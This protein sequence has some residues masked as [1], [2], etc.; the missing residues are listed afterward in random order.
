MTQDPLGGSPSTPLADAWHRLGDPLRIGIA[1]TSGEDHEVRYANPAFARL[2]TSDRDPTGRPVADVLPPAVRELLVP[3]LDRT[4]T[5]GE[6]GGPFDVSLVGADASDSI[7][8]CRLVPFDSGGGRRG[9]L[10]ELDDLSTH[11]GSDRLRTPA[12]E[13]LVG[14]NQRLVLA[15]LREQ[16]LAEEAQAGNRA[17]SDFLSAISHELRT[18][19]TAVVGYAELLES[20]AAGPLTE[21]Q[22]RSVERIQ[23][24]ALYLRD[25]INE[26]LKFQG[27]EAGRSRVALYACE[28]REIARQAFSIASAYGTN[29][30]EP[31]LE[32]PD[33][34]IPMRTDQ[35]K[36]KQILVNLLTNALKFT[37]RGSVVLRVKGDGDQVAFAVADTGPGIDPA[38]FERIFER[39]VQLDRGDSRAVSGTGLGLS[40]A[41][42]LVRLLEGKIEVAS[43][44]GDGATFTVRVPAVLSDERS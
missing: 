36:L 22:K 11:R 40:I 5:S 21:K 41:R 39:F 8:S 31:R 16:E 30:V 9:V 20:E 28:G 1:V 4:W 35:Q 6:V 12:E 37:E 18:P 25:L 15:A 42:H 2:L 38:D 3:L 27:L 10:I 13:E 24:A 14:L 19:L 7:C 23:T 26:V 29:C 17:K 33:E 32:L 43:R 44:R 34:A